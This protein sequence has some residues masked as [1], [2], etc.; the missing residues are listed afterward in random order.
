M[1]TWLVGQVVQAAEPAAPPLADRFESE[2]RPLLEAYCYHCHGIEETEAE[3]DLTTFETIEDVQAAPQIWEK[4]GEI[5]DSRQMPPEDATQPSAAERERL[6]QWVREHLTAEARAHAGDPGPVVLRR[7][8][9]S[10]YTYTLRD[11]TGVETLDP[12]REFPIDGAAGEGFTN[13]GTAL[14]M[15]PTLI[16]K[17]LAA[18]RDVAD[19]AVLLPDGI[20]F[21]SHTTRSDWKNEWLARL[22]RFYHRHVN[23]G[24]GW[25]AD[26]TTSH[27][28]GQHE[29]D[30]YP[31]PLERM[32]TTLLTAREALASG[33]QT[34]AAVAH[35]NDLNAKYLTTLWG[36]LNTDAPQPSMLLDALRQRWREAVNDDSPKLARQIEQ[37]Q[38]ALWKFNPIG[39]IGRAGGP[40]AWMEPVTPIAM[41]QEFVLDLA[42]L[43]AAEGT[44]VFLTANTAGDG[45]EHDWV[46]WERPRL[47]LP[48]GGELLLRDVPLAAEAFAN[49]RQTSS[50]GGLLLATTV[51]SQPQAWGLDTLGVGPEPRDANRRDLPAADSA[52]EV[53]SHSVCVHAPATIR[54]RLP[55]SWTGGTKFAVAGTLHEVAG[56]EG[57]A[58]LDV[59]TAPP[60]AAS[61]DALSSSLLPGLSPTRPHPCHRRKCCPATL[62]AELRRLPPALSPG[63]LLSTDRPRR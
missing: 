4:V 44:E 3:I 21:S 26:E 36:V 54:V 51:G 39:H 41:R 50:L 22:Q 57:T 40:T 38:Q 32:L 59:Q 63:T 27:A 35:A 48:D 49:L 8:S 2:T 6:H 52:P 30:G 18:A 9:N 13:A 10:E 34:P 28:E 55:A 53:E 46:V 31:P 20:R 23:H 5:L 43:P 11:L 60:S 15:S 12:A 33:Q 24:S 29:Q 14:V 58:Q 1:G 61:T 45:D 7:L 56:R 17:Y 19:H 42:P 47:V 16:E 37:W 62:R 25:T